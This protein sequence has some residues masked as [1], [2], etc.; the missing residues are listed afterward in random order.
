VTDSDRLVTVCDKCRRASC[1]Y[2]EFMC[3]DS[4]WAGTIKIP[5]SV[6]RKEAREHPR[7]W[8]EEAVR[9]GGTT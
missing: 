6:L 8:T 2:G 4:Q 3:E 5:V 1:W 9:N 7:Y